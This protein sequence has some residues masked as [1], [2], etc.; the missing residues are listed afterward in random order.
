MALDPSNSGNLEQLVLKGLTG[1]S[2][3]DSGRFLFH[4]QTLQ[5]KRCFNI[6]DFTPVDKRMYTVSQKACHCVFD[7]NINNNCPI[8]TT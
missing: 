6:L 3:R 7:D 1:S 5:F 2:V 4:V 8:I